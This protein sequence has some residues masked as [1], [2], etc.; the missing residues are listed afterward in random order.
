MK[1]YLIFIFFSISLGI[2]GQNN[3]QEDKLLNLMQTELN[4]NMQLLEKEKNPV[5]LLSY[6]IEDVQKQSLASEF[7]A[8]FDSK[9]TST[10]RLTIQVRVGSKEFDNFQE[11]RKLDYSM[12]SS[13]ISIGITLSLDDDSKSIQ[14]TLWRET[15]R[16]YR[17]AVKKYEHIKTSK[18]LLVEKEDKSPDYS[19]AEVVEYYEKPILF[20]DL[21]FSTK[22]WEE[23]IKTY[24]ALFANEKE[25]LKGR[26]SIS[27]LLER[28][29]FVNS[30]GTKIAQNQTATHLRVFSQTQ[31]DDGMVLPMYK[32][33]FS[34]LPSE[35]PEDSTVISDIQTI[36]E[37]LTLMRTA[38][39]VD[40]YDGP[41]I[42]SKEAAGVF[43]HEI[44]GHRVEGYRMKNET[45][46]Q[47]YKKKVNEEILHP[48]IS[49]IF[50]PTIKE[51]KG[52]LLNGSYQY[53]D[54]GVKGE[55]VVVVDR[56]VLKNFLMTRTPIENFPKSNGHARAASY[57]QPVSRQSNLI[58]ETIRPYTDEE[59]RK[60][61]IKELKEQ[62]KPHGYRFEQVRGGFTL[63]GRYFPNS[64]N[65]TPLEVYRVY[66]DGRPDE[67]VRG[68]DLVGT[69][70]T[71]FSQIEALGDTHG[72]FAG[73]CGAESGGV[74]VGCCSPSLFIKRIEI[75]RKAKNQDITPILE[76]PFDPQKN[77]QQDDF[78]TIAFKAMED[79]M[80]RS[81]ELRLD[82][83]ESPYYISYLVTD[84]KTMTV[85]SSLG[86]V[87]KS[88][89]TPYRSQSTTVLVG[90]NTL[91]NL[92][93][94]SDESDIFFD[95]NNNSYFSIEDDYNS[96]R[97]SLWSSTDD[98]YKKAVQTLESKKTAIKQQNLPEEE[99]NLPDFSSVPILTKIIESQKEDLNITN[100]EEL[101]KELSL[102]FEDYPHFINSMATIDVFQA[103][104]LYL[105]SEG[106]K[107]K[108]PV[109]LVKL[110]VTASVRA[111]DGEILEDN[112]SVYTKKIN[113][114]PD[115]ET[116][117]KQV[118]QM[119]TMLDA[120]TKAPIMN[121]IYKGPVMFDSDA[122]GYIVSQS[123]FNNSAG[124]ISKRKKIESVSSSF[125]I[126]AL[127][128]G[129]NPKENKYEMQ[130]GKQIIDKNISLTAIN[131]TKSFENQPLIGAYEIDAEGVMVADRLPLI[132]NGTL[133]TLLKDRIPTQK[134][135]HSNAHKRFSIQ[136]SY[137][138]PS[139]APGVVEMTGKKT[140]D[141]KKMK[142]QLI[143]AA[144]KKGFEY[145][146]VVQKIG[147]IT[148]M[149]DD[150]VSSMSRITSSFNSVKPVYIYRISVK[151]GSETLM[152][153]ATMSSVSLES[154][155]EVVSIANQQ[156]VCNILSS[157][158]GG[159]LGA[160]F[161]DNNGTPC[162]LILPKAIILNNIEIK[163]DQGTVFQKTP[164]S[165]N[166]LVK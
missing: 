143:A 97:E 42:L 19:D 123:F 135:S 56:G 72:N 16:A 117:K 29:Y 166:P 119:A 132:E 146:Y 113:Q 77:I 53:D 67:L 69:P 14:Q 24:S 51:Y 129:E 141:M 35:L 27:V 9:K 106:I 154:F 68:V 103:D 15:E 93:Y 102:V 131:N 87:I 121:E 118:H 110:N 13:G 30:E 5:Y 99:K 89:E 142:K 158:S 109:S 100:I 7:G 33:Y 107:Y 8:L 50:D 31:A 105:N 81:L 94:S 49:V 71:M 138:N 149:L 101:V 88:K 60:M 115:K 85:S 134:I 139:L 45:D 48:D 28:K 90:N 58:V 64:F 137:L 147:N 40:A 116:L 59:L 23:K 74:P 78:A 162:S 43:F 11:T 112:I 156:Q 6:R 52:N 63:T 152:R 163:K 37:K 140:T 22:Q 126:F 95:D 12:G 151:D 20:S 125:D 165:P 76:R 34:H 130:I 159:F 161:S 127:L 108:Q 66:A 21:D 79:E 136:S 4:R 32:S 91:N 73:T 153:M 114:L 17:A 57:Y 54:E 41:A 18:S 124:L 150:L 75:Q 98:Q 80:K 144:K 86:G 65:V 47:T 26:A 96:I 36:I 39:V 128:G 120:L 10:R 104:A 44:F 160:M 62:G 61:L 148:L 122:V 3:I 55:K 83:F 155:K 84:A 46:A 145:A 1:N 82:S 25:L 92:N 133:K 2:I 38:A 70:L 157:S 164:V 111:D